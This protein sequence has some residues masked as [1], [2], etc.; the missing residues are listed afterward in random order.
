MESRATFAELYCQNR[1]LAPER[2]VEDVLAQSLYPH[3]HILFVFLVWLRPD[4]GVADIDFI[5]G[6]GQLTRLQDFWAE[7]DDFG[8]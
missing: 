8:P 3:A 1:N 5:G 7:A 4:Y 2:F 6:V